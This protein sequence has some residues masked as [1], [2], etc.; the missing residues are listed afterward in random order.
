MEDDTKKPDSTEHNLIEDGN[1]SRP[2]PTSKV[3]FDE[4]VTAAEPGD[5]AA[6]VEAAVEAAQTEA[7]RRTGDPLLGAL[8]GDRFKVTSRIG[9]GGMGVVYKARQVGM[10]R[11]VAVKVLLKELTHDTKVIKRFKIE[12][13]A[14]SRLTHPNTIR[15]YDFGISQDD[16]LYIAME[17]LDGSSLERVIR[18]DA[19][20]SARRTLHILKQIA[21]SLSEAHDKGIVHRDLKPDNIFLTSVDGDQDFVKVLDFGVAKLKEADRKQGTLT[22]AGVIFGTPR[23]MA[24]EQCRS[25][26]VDH[27]A[28]LYALGVIGYECLTGDTP[29]EAE[30]PL[31]ILIKHVQEAPKPFSEARPDVE[32]PED[33]E[34][35]VM[36]CLEKDAEDRFGS[37]KDIVAEASRIEARLAGR[38]ERVVFVTGPRKVPRPGRDPSEAK[39]SL[40]TVS[41]QEELEPRPSRWPWIAGSVALVC[42]VLGILWAVGV[43][44]P[45]LKSPG[46]VNPTPDSGVHASDAWESIDVDAGSGV[47]DAL[48]TRATDPGI[49]ETGPADTGG[50]DI[51][52]SR[53]NKPRT[54]KKNRKNKRKGKSADKSEK[55]A[56]KPAGWTPKNDNPLLP[57]GF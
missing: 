25:L 24:P 33:V 54:S 22:Q 30:N 55:P 43:G 32:I 49:V 44:G 1:E 29:F 52:V 4:K 37:A 11:W 41:V 31:S 51:K 36:R 20:L 38:Y 5:V 17:F 12:A 7:E 23:Y 28:D 46:V 27:R 40:D 47:L 34:A 57:T 15:I 50:A 10:D 53:R 19:P 45:G 6:R 9:T 2:E 48:E 18:N 26:A 16:I 3:P 56:K 42:L 13:L 14:A 21:S 35:L 8:M 39:T